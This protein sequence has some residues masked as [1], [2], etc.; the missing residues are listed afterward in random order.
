MTL[1]T[2]ASFCCA[3]WG[4]IIGASNR[5]VITSP[6]FPIVNTVFF[7]FKDD[8]EKKLRPLDS[9]APS[10]SSLV[11]ASSNYGPKIEKII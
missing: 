5:E 3:L 11:A 4:I 9:A 8:F 2:L 7:C 10:K 6:R 1:L